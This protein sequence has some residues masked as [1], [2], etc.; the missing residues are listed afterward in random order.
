MTL[1]FQVPHYVAPWM[2]IR[3]WEKLKLEKNIEDWILQSWNMS[4][5]EVFLPK[6]RCHRCHGCFLP[7]VWCNGW[8][9]SPGRSW[10]V[11]SYRNWQWNWFC[12]AGARF[13][14]LPSPV[15]FWKKNSFV[16][17]YRLYSTYSSDP[18]GIQ[19]LTL[20][21]HSETSL[22]ISQSASGL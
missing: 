19:N 11:N 20:D 5:L 22:H 7:R 21:T 1:I 9:S 17:G 2:G 18:I 14:F 12:L 16:T 3:C 6:L 13:S 4:I 15:V 10:H 8:C